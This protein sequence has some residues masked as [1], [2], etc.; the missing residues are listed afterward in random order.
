[1]FTA[2]SRFHINAFANDIIVLVVIAAL[3]DAFAVHFAVTVERQLLGSECNQAK[4]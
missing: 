3:T 2:H 1:M 4:A